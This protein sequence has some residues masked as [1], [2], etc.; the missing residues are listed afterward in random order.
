MTEITEKPEVTFTATGL[1]QSPGCAFYYLREHLSITVKA[2]VDKDGKVTRPSY[3]TTLTRP[4]ACV[5]V[6]RGPR[7]KGERNK[8]V[9][10]GIALCSPK[11]NFSKKEGRS[12]AYN[13]LR[14]AE[15]G[16]WHDTE[17]FQDKRLEDILGKQ[18]PASR[19][20]KPTDYEQKLLDDMQERESA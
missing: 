20:L 6:R 3:N 16:D 14:M 19:T 9:S 18:R 15:N 4:F 5:A 2:K 8:W 1:I 11:D 13:R 7:M 17:F 12:K 10:R